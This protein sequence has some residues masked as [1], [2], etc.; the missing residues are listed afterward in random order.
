M[1]WK[2]VSGSVRM[3]GCVVRCNLRGCEVVRGEGRGS[4]GIISRDQLS[5]NQLSQD[6]LSQDQFSQDQLMIM[7]LI[8]DI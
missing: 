8:W 7:H 1:R 5:R 2:C 4:E 3:R 6:Q